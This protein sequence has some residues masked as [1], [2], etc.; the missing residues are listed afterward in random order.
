MHARHFFVTIALALSALPVCAQKSDA[1]LTIKLDAESTQANGLD[2]G[3]SFRGVTITQGDTFIKANEASSSGLDFRNSTWTFAGEVRFGARGTTASAGQAVLEFREQELVS[4]TLT[5]S[6]VKV[7]QAAPTRVDL[8]S[9]RARLEFVNSAL[10]KAQFNGGPV[11][12]RQRAAELTTDARADSLLF[13]ALSG[14]VTLQD[15]AWISEGSREITGNKISY[16]YVSRSVVAAGDE[17]E[18]VT[19][20]IA[21]PSDSE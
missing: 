13:D 1:R 17:N 4:A 15:N 20:T 16:N 3:I 11:S 2:G 12:Y 8:S 9:T 5:G 21:P 19:I 7:S 14:V 18:R 6:P 10:S